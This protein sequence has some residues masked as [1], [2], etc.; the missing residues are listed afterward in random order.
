MTKH[1]AGR[2]GHRT[3]KTQNGLGFLL[4]G[5]MI[6]LVRVDVEQKTVARKVWGLRLDLSPEIFHILSH[7]RI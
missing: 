4:S 2:D 5:C 6:L 3:K 7:R 1:F